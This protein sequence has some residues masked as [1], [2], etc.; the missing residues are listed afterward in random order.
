MIL[1]PFRTEE[2][3]RY[4]PGE[5]LSSWRES[6]VEF[7]EYE[8]IRLGVRARLL[9]PCSCCNTAELIGFIRCLISQTDLDSAPDEL[10]CSEMSS[11]TIFTCSRGKIEKTTVSL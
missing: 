8:L 3:T 11:H 1:A 5:S 9:S 7:E 4:G 6:A 10:Q 2:L